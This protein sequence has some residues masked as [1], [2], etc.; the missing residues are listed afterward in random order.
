M[1]TMPAQ[2][3]QAIYAIYAWCREVD[4][5]ADG[6][7]ARDEKIERLAA[8][9]SESEALYEGRPGTLSGIALR[10][11]V[12]AYRL[13]QQDFMEIL[14]GM[15]SD[16]AEEFRCA[17]EREHLER[18][19][20]RVAGSVGRLSLAVSGYREA[21][22]DQLACHLGR[23][24]QMT[25]ILR[26]INEDAA[27]GRVYIPANLF[28]TSTAGDDSDGSS[29]DGARS[30]ITADNIRA[31]PALPRACAALARIAES[32]YSKAAE[33]LAAPETPRMPLIAVTV[34]VYGALF[35]KMSWRGWDESGERMHL[36]KIVRIGLAIRHG[37]F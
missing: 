3:R 9:Y 34:A 22:A 26:D 16:A 37:L 24:L 29:M 21:S 30:E 25:N 1:R 27:R 15:E 33:I 8:C 11:P 31:H 6:D 12:A 35:R 13:E 18:Y 7:L 23:A 10:A 28:H 2:Q 5:I 19:C 32:H 4:D 14:R 17:P 20:D 36:S